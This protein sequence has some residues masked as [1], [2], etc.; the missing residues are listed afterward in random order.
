MVRAGGRA[1]RLPDS[2]RDVDL[3]R[4]APLQ[5]ILHALARKR[6]DSPGEGLALEEIV[7][8]GWPGERIRESARANRV[9]VALTTLRN[10]GLRA[11]LASGPSGYAL[12]P[13]IPFEL[14]EE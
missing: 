5:R 10:L 7:A 9:Y 3:R 12:A 13:S 8:A 2:T 1:F 4:R 14:T 6:L 11:F